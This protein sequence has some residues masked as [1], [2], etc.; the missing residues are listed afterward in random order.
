MWFLYVMQV[1]QKIANILGLG[2]K[3][4]ELVTEGLFTIKMQ[5]KED[6][7]TKCANPNMLK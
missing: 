1:T 6:K 2:K 5:R 3:K 7:S 4:I